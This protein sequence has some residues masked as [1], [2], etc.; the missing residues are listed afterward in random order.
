[1]DT[2]AFNVIEDYEGLE[3]YDTYFHCH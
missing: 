3:R 1:M 2:F